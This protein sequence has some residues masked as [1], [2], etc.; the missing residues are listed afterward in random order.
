MTN[1]LEHVCVK[2]CGKPSSL[3]I[4]FYP[5]NQQPSWPA[6]WPAGF[7]MPAKMSPVGAGRARCSHLSATFPGVCFFDA[8]CEMICIYESQARPWGVRAVPP[9]RAHEAKG[10]NPKCASR[11]RPYLS[12]CQNPLPRVLQSCRRE[13]RG[14]TPS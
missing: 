11:H 13:L 3:T 4:F 8:D 6:S 2:Q 9:H 10:P 5:A 7:F 14:R 1:N 12:C